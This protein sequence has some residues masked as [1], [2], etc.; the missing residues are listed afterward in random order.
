[1]PIRLDEVLRACISIEKTWNLNFIWTK[2]AFKYGTHYDF[3]TQ[4]L[5]SI[6]QIE[7]FIMHIR[8]NEN[9]K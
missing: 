4:L 9:R 1:M 3:A 6:I 7:I 2:L 8:M 5:I